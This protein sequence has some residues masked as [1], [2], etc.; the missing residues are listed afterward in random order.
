V[1]L[2]LGTLKLNQARESGLMCVLLGSASQCFAKIPGGIIKGH[3]V[4]RSLSPANLQSKVFQRTSD[5]SED[6]VESIFTIYEEAKQEA[7][8]KIVAKLHVAFFLG[9]VPPKRPLVISGLHDI[10]SLKTELFVTTAGRT[11]NP[12][13]LEKSVAAAHYIGPR[14]LPCTYLATH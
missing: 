2:S 8:V 11:T 1:H 5:V 12:K 9:N 13:C 4:H 3:N 14:P 7:T 6:Y 10:I